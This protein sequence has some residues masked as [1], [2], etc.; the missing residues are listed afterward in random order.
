MAFISFF[1]PGPF[2]PSVDVWWFRDLGSHLGCAPSQVYDLELFTERPKGLVLL[3]LLFFHS[4]T[5]LM[6]VVMERGHCGQPPR[7]VVHLCNIMIV[8]KLWGQNA[9]VCI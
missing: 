8:Y 5:E 3:L 9:C 1:C 6:M 4:T 7:I 2:I